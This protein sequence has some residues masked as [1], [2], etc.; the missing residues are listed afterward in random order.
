MN[1][2]RHAYLILAY[3]QWELL[4]TLIRMIDDDR[5]DIYIHVDL[6]SSFSEDIKKE[7]INSTLHSQVFFVDRNIVLR[8]TYTISEV[9]LYMIKYAL[10]HKQYR[11]LHLLSG[12]DLPIKSQEY[13]H[14]LFEANDGKNFIDLI[15]P[16]SVKKRWYERTSL[17]NFFLEQTFGQKGIVAN[18]CRNTN[19]VLLVLQRLAKVNRFHKYEKMGYQLCIGSSWFS[20]TDEFAQYL[21]LNENVIKSIYSRFTSISEESFLQT[22]FYSSPFKDSI[23][24]T[25]Q[26][27][28]TC[29]GNLRFIVWTG[30]TSPET[31]KMTMLNDIMNSPA[32]FARK[33]D[34]EVDSEVIH[35]ICEL[36]V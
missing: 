12:Q 28:D 11:Y 13:I 25:Y 29:R 17:Y 5:N 7:L 3:H 31:I 20:I 18:I 32:I 14:K 30:K 34:L 9:E 22:I 26:G 16:K 27:E 21:L 6:K 23:Y 33:F 4:R 10:S 19:R 35:R 8:G 15:P 24:Q 36:F 1:M 2:K